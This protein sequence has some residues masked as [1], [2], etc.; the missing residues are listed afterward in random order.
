MAAEWFELAIKTSGVATSLRLNL[1]SLKGAKVVFNTSLPTP[2]FKETSTVLL[3]LKTKVMWR[4]RPS[5]SIRGR[6]ALSLNSLRPLKET[7]E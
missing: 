6:S 4:K 5:K 1:T 3:E 2:A 7:E